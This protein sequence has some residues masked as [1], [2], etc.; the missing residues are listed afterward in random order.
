MVSD[1]LIGSMHGYFIIGVTC[2]TALPCFSPVAA[3][4]G[5][6]DVCATTAGFIA[7]FFGPATYD[8]GTYFFHYAGTDG[9]N[10]ALVV[11][12]WK[13][14]SCD[15]GGNHGDIATASTFGPQA[16]TC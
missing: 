1:G 8:V 4:G 7:T 16:L 12:E 2:A 3:C 6:P 11:H 10:Q 5:S 9:T 13:N 14:A 15:R